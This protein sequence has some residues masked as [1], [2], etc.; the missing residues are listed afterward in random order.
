MINN[1]ILNNFKIKI[2]MYNNIVLIKSE[3]L[4]KFYV[5]F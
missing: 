3:N 4:I 2:I 1:Y 5:C